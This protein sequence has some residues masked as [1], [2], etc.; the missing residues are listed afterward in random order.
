MSAKGGVL[1]LQ[2]RLEGVVCDIFFG[3]RSEEYVERCFANSSYNIRRPDTSA[4]TSRVI[5][6]IFPVPQSEDGRFTQNIKRAVEY[7]PYYKVRNGRSTEETNAGSGIFSITQRDKWS[8]T[9]KGTV[10][11]G[12]F[13][14]QPKKEWSIKRRIVF[15]IS[16]YCGERSCRYMEE[17]RV[18]CGI[19]P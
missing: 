13:V 19:F 10:T 6:G 14:V 4:E 5:C 3:L 7:S 1:N 8:S 9:E 12:I 2:G 11:S 18:A 17:N 15:E 16:P